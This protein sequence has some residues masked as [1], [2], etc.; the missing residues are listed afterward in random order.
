LTLLAATGLVA[1]I[2]RLASSIVASPQAPL[3]ARLVAVPSVTL[4]CLLLLFASFRPLEPAMALGL[5][6]SAALVGGLSARHCLAQRQRRAGALVLGLV[7]AA[8]LIHVLS[9]KLTQDASEAA[10]LAVFRG[11][12][13]L[14]TLGLGVD[15]VALALACV[16]LQRRARHGRVLVPVVLALAGLLVVLGLRGFA[17]GASTFNVLLSRALEELRRDQSS[18]LPPALGYMLST[19]SLLGALAAL[20]L[21]GELGLVLAACLAA[22]S[23]LDIPVPALMLEL[24]ALYLPL[25]RVGE[26]EARP[27]P[28]SS[29][30]PAKAGASPP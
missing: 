2:A 17:P 23:A 5:G 26:E 30:A 19:T 14:E 6:L 7:A 28:E 8:G 16:W 9:R 27:A 25:A 21:G 15:L 24:G 12:E 4:G 10:N 11:A 18:L 13:L 3:V 22:R 1:G 20:A 29:D